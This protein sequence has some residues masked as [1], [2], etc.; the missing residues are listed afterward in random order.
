MKGVFFWF[1]LI[2]NLLLEN[3]R[4]KIV[5]FLFTRVIR[6]IQTVS[7][8]DLAIKTRNSMKSEQSITYLHSTS[9]KRKFHFESVKYL[10][11]FG[12]NQNYCYKIFQVGLIWHCHR[13]FIKI[14]VI[15][16]GEC[17]YVIEWPFSSSIWWQ[18]P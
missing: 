11:F 9:K 12:L 15:V 5:L 3:Y 6:Y 18:L 4:K 8:P 10:T 1:A 16:T 17:I 2:E 7:G 14:K 13:K